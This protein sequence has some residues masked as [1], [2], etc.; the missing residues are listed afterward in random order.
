MDELPKSIVDFYEEKNFNKVDQLLRD[1]YYTLYDI[2]VEEL[3]ELLTLTTERAIILKI[4][5]VLTANL[6]KITKDLMNIYKKTDNPFLKEIL[7]IVL[8]SDINHRNLLFIID[9]YL[10]HENHRYRISKTLL[11]EEESTFLGLTNY[12]EQNKTTLTKE[13]YEILKELLAK[14]DPKY[15]HKYSNKFSYLKISDL[16]YSIDPTKFEKNAL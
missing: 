7:L 3:I 14:I 16:F 12:V 5:L 4:S 13:D 10:K 9:A 15:Y 11:K 8:T 6:T 2:P 1:Y